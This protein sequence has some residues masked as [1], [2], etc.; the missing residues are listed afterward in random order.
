[1]NVQKERKYRD[2]IEHE[3]KS[4]QKNLL[5]GKSKVNVVN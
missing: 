1:M 5:V 4:Q 3:E 2:R